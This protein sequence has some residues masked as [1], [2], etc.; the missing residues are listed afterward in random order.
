MSSSK[1]SRKSDEGWYSDVCSYYK[2]LHISI[3]IGFVWICPIMDCDEVYNYWEPLHFIHYGIG[4]MQTWEYAPQYAL[5]TYA[6]LL[7]M[8]LMVTLYQ[9]LLGNNKVM[10]F[11]TLRS[12]LALASALSEWKFITTTTTTSSQWILALL[13]LTSCGMFHASSSYLPSST[14]MIFVMNVLSH[15]YQRQYTIAIFYGLLAVLAVGWPFCAVLF[16][17]LAM[18]SILYH[19]SN[20]GRSA[21]GIHL[22]RT[23]T[24]AIV[25]QGIICSIDAQYYQSFQIP[26]WNIFYYNVSGGG[27][28]HYGIEPFSYYIKNLWLNFNMVGF[29]G[30][31]SLP[32]C[33]LFQS[34][35]KKQNHRANAIIYVPMYLWLVMVVPRHHKE[36]RFLYPIYSILCHGTTMILSSFLSLIGNKKY[37]FWIL[38]LT[39]GHCIGLSILRIMALSHGYMAPQYLYSHLYSTFTME[40]TNKETT[41]V[42]TCGEWYRFPSFYFLP[43]R[44]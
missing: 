30:I 28:E 44:V 21:V 5:R 36:E 3:R 19:Y 35:T 20:S 37:Q 4:G 24:M 41:M 22:L 2:V 31:L 40:N 6:Y 43:T 33:F 23:A 38:L 7:P 39:V 18:D 1:N 12:T 8:K 34:F 13:L 14:V 25:L 32:L 9:F 26:I 10:L 11:Y 27:D 42:S 15:P 16:L 17:P 29:M